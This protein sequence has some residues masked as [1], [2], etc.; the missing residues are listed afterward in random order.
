MN[1]YFFVGQDAPHK[2][3]IRNI[4]RFFEE[5]KDKPEVRKK[6]IEDMLLS[7]PSASKTS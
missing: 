5:T 1:Y 6:H 4:Y 7:L 3:I 2:R